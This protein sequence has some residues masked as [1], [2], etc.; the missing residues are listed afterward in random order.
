MKYQYGTVTK[1]LVGEL[2]AIVGKPNLMIDLERIENY[3]HDETSKEEYAHT[4][5]L[6]LTPTSALQIAAIMK[7][8]TRERIPV[9]PRGAGSGLS[10]GAIPLFGGIVL[11][12]EKMNKVLEIDEANLTVTAEA[13]IVTNELNEQLKSRG[14]FFA[15]YPMSLETC[16]LGGNIAEN[17]GGGK[18]VKYGVTGR[19]ILGME[20]VT[21]QGDIVELGGKV[22]KDVSG[23]DLKQLYIGSEGTLGIITKATIKLLGVPKVASNLLVPFA[24]AQEA[25]AVVPLIMKQGII[26]TSIEF[27]DR[28]SIEL[29][30]SYLNES[31]PLEGVGAMLLIEIDG[32]DEQTVERELIQVGDLCS[33]QGAMEVYIAEDATTRERIWSVRRNIAEAIKVYSPIQSLE[34]VVVPIASIPLVLPRLEQLKAKYQVSIPC[35]GHAGDG[36]LHATIVKDPQMSLD[37][38]KDLEPKLLSELYAFITGELGGKISGEHGIGL[39]RKGYLKAVTPPAEYQLFKALKAAFDPLYIMNPG[40]ILD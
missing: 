13:G 37:D 33:E 12:V 40:K 24:S 6:V 7:L 3:S 20:V 39:K 23:Y 29:T 1:A 38:W 27:M 14:L 9:T 10:G 17:A 19:Y 36:N 35:Y 8:A 30:C 16:F 15:G 21:P 11:S 32:T 22:T 28:S 26:P 2:Q 25:I 5:D 31:L 4:P 18:A 34:D